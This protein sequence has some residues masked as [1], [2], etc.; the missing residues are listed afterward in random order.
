MRI[1]N[2][3]SILILISSNASNAVFASGVGTAFNQREKFKNVTVL[4]NPDEAK[5]FIKKDG[6]VSNIGSLNDASLTGE[7]N[8]ALRSS[9]LG[10]FL[11]HTELKKMDAINQHKINP[12][13]SLLKESLKIEQN[14][15]AKTGGG[16]LSASETSTTS[17]INKSCVEGVDFNVD[18]GL[19]LVLEAEEKEEIIR[20]PQTSINLPARLIPEI[21]WEKKPE[22]Y[23]TTDNELMSGVKYVLL[24]TVEAH[25]AIKEA[26]SQSVGNL[27][28]EFIELPSQNVFI[29]YPGSNNVIIPMGAE[30]FRNPAIK[31]RTSAAE[32]ARLA[33]NQVTA[34]LYYSTFEI[35][36]KFIEKGEY[37]QVATTPAEKLVEEN[38]CYET[39]RVCTRK[40]IKKFFN[41]YNITRPCWSEK[42][43]YE[44]TSKP[45]DGCAH[46]TK[47]N[48]RLVDSECEYRIGNICL[49]WKRNF[50]C[51]IT[52]KERNYS[53]AD[54]SIYCLGGNCHTPTI[55]ENQ[56]F[57]NVAYLAAINEAQKDCDKESSGIC[58]KPITVF[59][60]K[61]NGCDNAIAGFINC[62]SA[63][64]G[65]GKDMKLSS[66]SPEEKGLALKRDKGLCHM[67]GTYCETRES[68]TKV[69]L[70]KRTNFCCFNS[71]LARIFHEQ[72][73]SQLNID[74]GSSEFPNCRPLTL[75]E[76]TKLD[77]SKFDM[78]ELF[79][80]MLAK[81]KS[82]MFK[83][84]PSIAPKK[85]PKLQQEHMN[86]TPAEKRDI[87][88]RKAEEEERARRAK[89]EEKRLA[90]EARLKAQ[91][92]KVRLAEELRAREERKKFL[93]K[94]RIRREQEQLRI[95]EENRIKR[96]QALALHKQ[97]E[98]VRLRQEKQAW[99]N[100]YIAN[101]RA[102]GN[103]EFDTIIL[104]YQFFSITPQEYINNPNYTA[105]TA[106]SRYGV[107]IVPPFEFKQRLFTE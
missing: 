82:N 100:N 74:W 20:K 59:A 1:F 9:E 41:K 62:C 86:T 26:I 63:N 98:L 87:L 8:N 77:Y 66:C 38:E 106:I 25:N 28:P 91:Q 32:L 107:N 57:G 94:E 12:D 34:I 58:K 47:Q 17:F 95:A 80:E 21:F 64:K 35:R 29:F 50:T 43:S 14:P 3:I 72:G 90:E 101:M 53:L 54:S 2:I 36:K 44:C 40:G 48:C 52:R 45:K 24:N 7:G 22:N 10:E 69:C 15:M 81:G 92:E 67:I 6:D 76:L 73:R 30:I 84:F 55:E 61:T 99:Y 13:N 5:T 18:V 96:Q 4:G 102:A 56:D 16:L 71:K 46:L 105:N 79:A 65:W 31:Y 68:V 23:R 78:E 11:Q 89:E 39:A 75:E 42:I 33:Y 104:W 97:N 70:V 85:L 49:R 88:K 93:E 19:E 51:P 37:W 103:A 60:G 83:T 27:S